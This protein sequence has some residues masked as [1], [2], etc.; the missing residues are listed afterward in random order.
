M[1]SRLA[2]GRGWWRRGTSASLANPT[3]TSRPP[4]TYPLQHLQRSPT[5]CFG[6]FGY[7]R[8]PQ[9]FRSPF[10]APRVHAPPNL[11]H[12]RVIA[13]RPNAYVRGAG[14]WG[15]HKSTSRTPSG[16]SPPRARGRGPRCSVWCRGYGGGGRRTEKPPDSPSQDQ[17]SGIR[18]DTMG[19]AGDAGDLT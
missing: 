1:E 2:S 15:G 19:R 11:T 17:N 4:Q 7:L 5:A 8:P 18:P 10:S 14:D 3:S 13:A 12:G 6:A 9:R 16:R